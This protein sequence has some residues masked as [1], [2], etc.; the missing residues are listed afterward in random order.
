M[1]DTRFATGS[2]TAYL[3][4]QVLALGPGGA[5]DVDA[6]ALC[7]TADWDAIVARADELRLDAVAMHQGDQVRLAVVG[8]VGVVVAATDGEHRFD[9][10]TTRVIE[11][12]EGAHH[13]TVM[14]GPGAEPTEAAYRTDGGAV[15][16]SII[17]RRL[18]APPEAPTDPFEALFGHTVARSVESAAIRPGAVAARRGPVGVL[19]FSTGERVVLDTDVVLGRNPRSIERRADD[20]RPGDGPPL[21]PAR[22]VTVSHPAVSRQ[23]VTIRVDR[24]LATIEDLGSANGTTVAAAGAPAT[25][26]RPGEPIELPIGSSVDL[27]GA[28]S[29]SVEEAA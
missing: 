10:G 14:V 20:H 11:L 19:V 5:V 17:S 12:V 2:A 7:A 23:H 28:V 16:A 9:G 8:S 4:D 18:A 15:P 21:V 22:P 1:T 6:M 26:L 29:F 24:C 13:V 27:G 3:T 25:T